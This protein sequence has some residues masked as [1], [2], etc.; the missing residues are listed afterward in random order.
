MQTPETFACKLHATALMTP[1]NKKAHFE[2]SSGISHL[3][4]CWQIGPHDHN[5]CKNKKIPAVYPVKLQNNVN[6][7]LRYKITRLTTSR[8]VEQ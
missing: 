7:V 1:A 3:V 8:L 5:F 6:I 2:A 4:T